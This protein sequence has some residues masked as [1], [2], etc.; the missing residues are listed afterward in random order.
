VSRVTSTVISLSS[1]TTVLPETIPSQVTGQP[2]HS[3]RAT[4]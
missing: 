4:R 3:H 2:D 1:V